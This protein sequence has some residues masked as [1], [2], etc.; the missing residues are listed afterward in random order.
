MAV[1]LLLYA[2]HCL[3]AG[4]QLQLARLAVLSIWLALLL[5]EDSCSCS[6]TEVTL[7]LPSTACSAV[8]GLL[9]WL[10]PGLLYW[11]GCTW[12]THAFAATFHLL[13]VLDALQSLVSGRSNMQLYSVAARCILGPPAVLVCTY[14]WVCLFCACRLVSGGLVLKII[15]V[16]CWVVLLQCSQG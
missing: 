11:Q 12:D 7:Q 5:Q 2:G 14:V 1:A 9:P 10:L 13:A 15:P 8:A 3:Y 6:S 4:L 16:C